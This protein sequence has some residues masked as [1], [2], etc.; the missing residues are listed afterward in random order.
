MSVWINV[1][2]LAA[3][4][5]IL[6]ACAELMH[7]QFKL[8][9]EITRKFVHLFTGFITLLFPIML[10]NHWVVLFLCTSFAVLLVLSKKFHFLPSINKINRSSMGSVLYPVVVYGCYFAGDYFESTLYFYTPILILAVADPVAAICGKKW[11]FGKYAVFGNSKTLV[12]S[13]AFFTAA[14]FTTWMLFWIQ[15]AIPHEKISIVFLLA[16]FTTLAEGVSHK[17]F[18]NLTV[19]AVALLLLIF[20]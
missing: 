12:G 9:A 17:G 18:D 6:F 4:F 13:G 10:Q 19:P 20:S 11:P 5:L 8:K 2:I 7:H 15:A 1:I 3:G 14:F 16:F